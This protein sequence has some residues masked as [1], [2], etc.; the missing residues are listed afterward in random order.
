MRINKYLSLCGVTSRRGAE[1]LIKK[2]RVIVNDLT[3]E[4]PGLVIDESKDVVKVNGTIVEPVERKYYILINK[5]RQ[6]LTTLH[7]PFHRPTVTNFLKKSPA[8]VYP[9]GRLDYD[10][11]GALLMTNDGELAYRL[12]HPKYE[13]EKIYLAEI[14]GP[15]KTEELE[16]LANGIKLD[17]GHLGKAEAEIIYA[18]MKVSRVRLVLREGHKREVKQLMKGI[19]HPVRRL[20]RTCFAGLKVDNLNPGRWRLLNDGEIRRLQKLVGIV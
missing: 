14:D 1:V 12:A 2:K 10:T 6:V 18:S 19:G 13:V 5:P 15:I 17:D 4:K 20:K 16:K 3:V 9:V 7:D 8:R 11:E